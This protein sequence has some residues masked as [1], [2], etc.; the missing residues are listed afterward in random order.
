ML[1][2]NFYLT[3][4]FILLSRKSS[5]KEENLFGDGVFNIPKNQPPPAPIVTQQQAI[6]Q[7]VAIADYVGTK[8][9]HLSFKQGDIIN[10]REQK[11]LWWSGEVKGRVN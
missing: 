11:D 10:L 6:P 3:I 7:A 8:S 9:N 5:I 1:I 4:T 2:I